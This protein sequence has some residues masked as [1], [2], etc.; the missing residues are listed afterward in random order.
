MDMS[1]AH[2]SKA[3]AAFLEK[4]EIKLDMIPKDAHHRL[5]LLERNHAVRREQLSIYVKTFPDDSLKT[6]LRMTAAQRNQLRNVDGYS[7]ALLVLGKQSN[8]PGAI[9]EEDFRLNEQSALTGTSKLTDIMERRT[10]AG[11][12]FLEANCSRAVRAPLIYSHPSDL[13]T[14]Q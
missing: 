13:F 2:S 9:V 10:A 4:R 8:V 5:G 3:M 7:P 6:A 11:K 1:G 12:A 14:P